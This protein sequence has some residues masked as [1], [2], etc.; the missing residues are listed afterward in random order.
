M[1][2]S[3]QRKNEIISFLSQFNIECKII[4]TF[5]SLYKKYFSDYKNVD[6][7]DL[8]QRNYTFN[9][10]DIYNEL[11][12]KSIAVTGA[13]GS[14]GSEIMNQLL[15]Y[16]PKLI[17]AL[18][19]SKFNLYKLE[20]NLLTLNINSKVKII[21]KLCDIRNTELIE[22]ILNKYSIEYVFHTSAYK[23]VLF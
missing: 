23:H 21:N 4:P 5:E 1:C 8:I 20:Q 16:K 10:K 19:N 12:N 9:N 14:I 18:D 13:G 2:I 17:I 7:S 11:F 22:N 6:I 3:Y 15:K